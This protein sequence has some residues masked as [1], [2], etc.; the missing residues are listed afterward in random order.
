M[1]CTACRG[2]CCEEFIV[3]AADVRPPG[4]DERRWLELHAVATGNILTGRELRF[5]CRCT[6][7]TAEGRCSVYA[8]R[9]RTCQTYRAGGPDCL[10]V[11]R[12]RRTPEQYAAI[13][14]AGDPERIHEL[15]P[16]AKATANAL[17]ASF[18][19]ATE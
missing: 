7:L 12:R 15:D 17:V 11:V 14:E 13:R 9:P 19:G 5:E 1:N 8:D 6:K 16:W 10:E 2:A 18:D 4:L 3:P